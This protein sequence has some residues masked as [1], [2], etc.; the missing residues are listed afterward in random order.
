MENK[1]LSERVKKE[2]ENWKERFEIPFSKEFQV[3]TLLKLQEEY[4]DIEPTEKNTMTRKTL[5]YMIQDLEHNLSL[6][7][8]TKTKNSSISDLDINKY[9]LFEDPTELF[10]ELLKKCD[11]IC[12]LF[13]FKEDEEGYL[14]ATPIWR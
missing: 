12:E 1:T 9:E 6:K 2:F 7:E 13:D 11:A 8:K 4:N 3:K 10:A 14:I 5:L